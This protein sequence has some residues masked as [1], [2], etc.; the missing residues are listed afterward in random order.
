[1]ETRVSYLLILSEMDI[2]RKKV[3][4]VINLNYF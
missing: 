3:Y 1:M 2:L 4:E